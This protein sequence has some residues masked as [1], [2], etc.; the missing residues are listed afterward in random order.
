MLKVFTE[1]LMPHAAEINANLSAIAAASSGRRL[2]QVCTS[3]GRRL[4]KL[5]RWLSCLSRT[6]ALV[7]SANILVPTSFSKDSAVQPRYNSECANIGRPL[8]LSYV[9]LEILLTMQALVHDL[10]SGLA[11][12]D[13]QA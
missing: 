4:V 13:P 7:K 9:I 5:S 10:K 2:Q 12:P 1:A 3:L 8:C 11:F 6:A